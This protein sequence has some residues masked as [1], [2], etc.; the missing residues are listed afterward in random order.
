MAVAG[1]G[2]A[3]SETST[4]SLPTSSTDYGEWVIARTSGST[5]FD[6]AILGGYSCSCNGRTVL[7]L[8][9]AADIDAPVQLGLT[10]SAD[11]NRTYLPYRR[12]PW[13]IHK[14]LTRPEPWHCDACD[15]EIGTIKRFDGL[16]VGVE[17]TCPLCDVRHSIDLALGQLPPELRQSA[18]AIERPPA[19]ISPPMYALLRQMWDAIQ[20]QPTNSFVYVP[21]EI[22][23]RCGLLVHASTRAQ[24]EAPL[25]FLEELVYAGLLADD[26]AISISPEGVITCLQRFGGSSALP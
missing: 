2:S 5:R 10:C 24:I 26:D 1:A 9:R 14:A 7:Q 23:E 21:Y 15:A 19:M 3:T 22:R 18:F 16:I 17:V 8:N 6:N 12:I 20:K 11:G 25:D 4:T 13:F